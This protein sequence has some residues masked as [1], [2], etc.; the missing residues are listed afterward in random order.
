MVFSATLFWSKIQI[1]R[2]AQH[3]QIK[4]PQKFANTVDAVFHTTGYVLCCMPFLSE[5]CMKIQEQIDLIKNLRL[6]PDFII[7][8]KVLC[9]YFAHFKMKQNF[10]NKVDIL[11][12][13]E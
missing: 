1:S 5:E 9:A 7:N 12:R 2:I 13:L 4:T 10:Q 8:I 3:T 6:P 11:A